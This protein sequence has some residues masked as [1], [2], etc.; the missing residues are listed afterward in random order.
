MRSCVLL[1]KSK[2]LGEEI[3]NQ[4]RTMDV[5]CTV[6]AFASAEEL[7][8][9][10]NSRRPDVF[11]LDWE[12]G[13]PS[14]NAEVVQK[15]R[16]VP[17]CKNTG[18]IVIG[19]ELT[20]QLLGVAA[21]HGAFRVFR[22]KAGDTQLPQSV[23]HFLNELKRPSALRSYL[24]RLEMA[25]EKGN[26]GDV[27][28]LSED[29]FRLFPDELRSLVEYANLC[30]RRGNV[31]GA[32]HVL[33]RARQAFPNDIRVVNLAARVFLKEG[34]YAEAL[35]ALEQADVLS[36]KNVERLGIFGDIYREKN[37]LSMARAYYDQ[38]LEVDPKHAQVRKA[39]GQIE[40]AEGE[41]NAALSLFRDTCSEEELAAVFNNAGIFAVRNRQFSEAQRMYQAAIGALSNAV[42]KSKVSFNLGLSFQKSMERE[43][44]LHAFQMAHNWD[45]SFEK[46][47]RAL[48]TMKLLSGL[49]DKSLNLGF[50]PET[51][52]NFE[53][54]LDFLEEAVGREESVSM[55][56]NGGPGMN[57]AASIEAMKRNNGKVLTKDSVRNLSPFTFQVLNAPLSDLDGHEAELISDGS[58]VG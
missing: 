46:N 50:D 57:E 32:R 2:R 47:N 22:S 51:V 24:T 44:A 36:P 30:L 33:Y 52:S 37:D 5:G 45:D 48:A 29:M 12:V 25:K 27:D 9:F 18:L 49:Q 13:D 42:L 14:Q 10:C 20:P 40:L 54:G 16:L 56:Q 19:R 4:F 34:N 38:A 39:K 8:T 58:K 53:N 41:V 11:I 55:V 43:K 26:V 28:R 1:S 21:E 3:P 6:A 31:E 23:R 7:V 35:L 17:G 15:I